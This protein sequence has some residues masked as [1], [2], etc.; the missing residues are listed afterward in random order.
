MALIM[1]TNSLKVSL[2]PSQ[3]LLSS[4]LSQFGISRTTGCSSFFSFG[5]SGTGT[6][7]LRVV[8]IPGKLTT[9]K[10]TSLF[11]IFV[12]PTE[13][14]TIRQKNGRGRLWGAGGYKNTSNMVN[15]SCTCTY[16]L[17]LC[18][19]HGIKVPIGE[20]VEVEVSGWVKQR[21]VCKLL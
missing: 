10:Y 3:Y 11:P 9:L 4:K 1:S 12:T 8:T 16:I 18:K 20:S 14:F 17:R 5:V 21:W 7:A 13:Y 2:V 19:E 6:Q 15:T